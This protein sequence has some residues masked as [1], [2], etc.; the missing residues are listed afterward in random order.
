VS[1]ALLATASAVVA[2]LLGLLVP[3]LVAAV[4]EPE[5]SEAASGEDAKPLYVDVSRRPR[6][7]LWA[8]L[9]SAAVAA[10]LALALGAEP[11]LVALVPLVPVCV[12]LAVIDWHTRLLPTRIVLPATAYAVVV[13][14]V[15]WPVSG[16]A[17][18]LVRAA[19]GLVVARSFY[20]LLW[21]IHS[22]GM[23]FGDVRLAALVGLALGH[24]GWAELVVGMY[25]G[26]LVFGLP[27]LVLALVRWDRAMLRTAFPFGPFMLVGAVV[28]V[29]TGPWVAAYLAWR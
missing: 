4:P 28:G 25:A 6:L 12:A 17:E 13:A 10:L 5:R 3:R 23:G 29:L 9:S 26:F 8:A 27:G 19:I 21:F 22:A 18:D 2:G 24:L 11:W 15:L 14:L 16:D 20:W 1:P 7:A